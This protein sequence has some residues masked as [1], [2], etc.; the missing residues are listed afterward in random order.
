[1]KKIGFVGVYDKADLIL[2]IAKVLNIVGKKVL[3][4]DNT[5]NQKCKYVVPVINP[6]KSYITEFDGIDVAVGFES[7]KDV[8]RYLGLEE[9]GQLE[10]DIMIVDTDNYEGLVKFDLQGAEKLY[11]VTSFDIYSLKKGIEIIKQINV[12]LHMTRLFYSKEMLKEEEEYFDYL[13]LGVKVIWNEEKLYFLLENGDQAAIIENQR[14]EKIK[15]RNLS[16]EYKDNVIFLVNDIDD[17]I[18]EK[19]IRNTIKNL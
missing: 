4:V 19:K 5:L 2:S 6:T 15:F 3:I 17:Q 16:N 1:M 8:R 18:G 14:V 13:A 11:Y 12:P 10:Y 7:T 9:D